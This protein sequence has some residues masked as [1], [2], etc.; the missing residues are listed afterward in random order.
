MSPSRVL[1]VVF[2]SWVFCIPTRGAVPRIYGVSTNSGRIGEVITVFG[3]DFIPDRALVLVGG[4]PAAVIMGSVG[5]LDV[6]VPGGAVAGR[7]SVTED[8]MTA[9]SS[10][11]FDPLPLSSGPLTNLYA[12][13]SITTNGGFLPVGA[14]ADL[15]GDGKSD[16]VT[17]RPTSLEI[18]LN[19]AREGLLNS[20]SFVGVSLPLKRAPTDIAARD[21][22]GDGR[23]DLIFIEGEMV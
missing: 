23:P 13:R 11:Y 6:R 2:F 12:Q 7:I 1:A 16:I 22:D 19:R 3:G 21:L 10:S 5:F 8:G 14:V 18:F 4:A 15:D 17:A 9:T 20:N